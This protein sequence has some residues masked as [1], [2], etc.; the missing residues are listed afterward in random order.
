MVGPNVAGSFV[1]VLPKAVQEASPLTVALGGLGLQMAATP[2]PEPAPFGPMP[3]QP[4]RDFSKYGYKGPLG[5]GR[6]TYA[7]PEDIAPIE[8]MTLYCL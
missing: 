2:P 8:H 7:D 6:Y 5:R 4:A 1:D 3:A